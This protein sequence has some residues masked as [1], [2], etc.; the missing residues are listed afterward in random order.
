MGAGGDMIAFWG[1]VAL[2]TGASLAFVLPRLIFPRPPQAAPT[3]EAANAAIHR[4]RL[5]ELAR[6]RAGGLLT[7]DE[8]R[9]AK[10]EIERR[11]L[12]D[13][14]GEPEAPAPAG[15][16]ARLV[17]ALAIAILFPLLALGL[18]ALFG[19]PHAVHRAPDAGAL[20]ATSGATYAL[21]T[22]E[23][24][25]AHLARNP[26]DGRS[27]VLLAQQ[28]ADADRFAEAA[29][30]Y[31]KALESS[32]KVANDPAIWCEYADALGMAQ[33]GSLTGRPR[34]LIARALVLGPTHPKAL[35]MAGSAAYE[36]GEFP[37][38]ARHWRDLLARIA[39]GSPAYRE[40]ATA[41]ARAEAQEAVAQAR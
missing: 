19:S 26:R 16:T 40:L 35:E 33:G 11:L 1:I 21:P 22:R 2:M 3:A 37:M 5:A 10:I 38:A 39:P 20:S 29:A 13:A 27:W 15:T 41:V 18:Y 8:H 34:E 32:P 24:L 4:S 14:G 12:D 25:A 30:A 28:E 23:A 9:R 36:A 31:G 7:D 17:P 6:E